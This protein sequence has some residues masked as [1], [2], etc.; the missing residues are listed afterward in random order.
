LQDSRAKSTAL[1]YE[2]GYKK[3]RIWCQAN[4]VQPLPGQ[5]VDFARFLSHLYQSNVP[6]SQIE[7]IFYS[8]KWFHD[9]HPLCVNNPCD[10]KFSHLLL[11][12]LKRRL[13]KPTTKK[14]PISPE[15]LRSIVQH[16]G[17]PGAVLSEVRV[18][19]LFLLTYAGF[20]R[21]D[22]ISRIRRCDI[23]MCNSY[24]KVFVASSKTDMYRQGAWVVVAAT[25]SP[26]C[27]MAMLTR[28]LRLALFDD[29]SDQAFLFRPVQF[30][31]NDNKYRLRKGNLS[32]TRC[33]E[34]FRQALVDI[35]VDPKPYG[36]HSLRAGGA[37][38]AANAGVAVRLFKRHGRWRSE[39]AKDGYV[40]D[41]LSNRLTVS[42]NLGIRYT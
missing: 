28:Y 27:P 30:F 39:F 23:V 42:K 8:V 20:F 38:A 18:C 26:T 41:S 15:L 9:R 7:S 25:G 36:F 2:L 35:G 14:L 1:K 32:Y 31:A 3:W 29:P 19:M 33:R 11:Q 37:T 40:D 34:I 24:F 17:K 21:F 4:N 6:Y 22:E 16:F 10:S 5:T 13:A 12:G